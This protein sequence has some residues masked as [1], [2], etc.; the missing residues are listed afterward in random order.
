MQ[1]ETYGKYRIVR[2]LQGGG[3][4]RVY[5]ALDSATGQ[6]VALK[7]IDLGPDQDSQDVLDAERRGAVLQARLSAIDSRVVKIGEV[8]ELEGCF[9]IVMEYIEGRDLSELLMQGP[10]APDRAVSIAIDVCEVLEN[11]HNFKAKLDDREYHGIV[12]GDIK[13]RNIRITTGSQVKVLD[14]GIAKALSLTHRFTQNQFGSVPYSSPERLNSGEVTAASDLWSA[15]VMLYE[16]VQGAPY[17]QVAPASA[18]ERAIRN[19]RALQPGLQTLP[20]VLRE[21]LARALAPNPAERYTTAQELCADLR[22]FREGKPL[23]GV[24]ADEATRRTTRSS[25]PGKTQRSAPP[26]KVLTPVPAAKGKKTPLRRILQAAALVVAGYFSWSEFHTIR[27][28]NQL[29]HDLESER[30]TDLNAAWDRY[31]KLQEY[32][33]L[34]LVA[35]ARSALKDKLTTSADRVLNDYRGSDSPTVREKD[36]QR[37]QAALARALELSPDDKNVKGKL[38][39]CEGQILRINA[40]GHNQGKTWND[41]K[42]KFE[43]ARELIPKSP[44]PHL[45]LARLHVY[46]LKDVEK[47]GQELREAERRGY[48]LGKREKAELA[49]GYRDRADRWLRES[50]SSHGFPQEEEYLRRADEDY[51]RAEDYYREVAPFGNASAMLRKI[52]ESRD[53][54]AAR[55]QQLRKQP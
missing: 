34:G 15:A 39:L 22:A 11:S 41:A 42:A 54:L 25:D 36:W 2:K 48:S 4:G 28:G 13:P 52:A 1:P 29:K 20:P 18:L 46:G 10:L 19:Y 31:Q 38:R 8:G 35:G 33:Y 37:A 16:M 26:A 32:S 7:L 5:L 53:S 51:S 3:M 6:Q 23:S 49:D 40:G 17:F 43:E 12:H 45:G 50:E 9:Y 27:E 30:L 44:D 14:F 55:I 21:I 47:A 24:A